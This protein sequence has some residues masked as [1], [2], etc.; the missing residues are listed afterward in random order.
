MLA[1]CLESQN[2]KVLYPVISWHCRVGWEPS[3]SIEVFYCSWSHIPPLLWLPDLVS[4]MF[5]QEA[6]IRWLLWLGSKEKAGGGDALWCHRLLSW[7]DSSGI[8]FL[9]RGEVEE[10]ILVGEGEALEDE[11]LPPPSDPEGRDER[12]GTGGALFLPKKPP[13]STPLFLTHPSAFT[14]SPPDP[15]LSPSSGCGWT[16]RLTSPPGIGLSGACR[17]DSWPPSAFAPPTPAV[18][19]APIFV[20]ELE[21]AVR[22]AQNSMAVALLSLSSGPKSQSERRASGAWLGPC[23]DV[24]PVRSKT[25]RLRLKFWKSLQKDRWMESVRV[26]MQTRSI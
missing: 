9:C 21:L 3:R 22:Q 24:W 18:I 11:S 14:P 1:S 20:V 16:F 19:I 25:P 7:L 2:K 6:S 13:S 10:A 23:V 15:T 5:L 12:C 8:S 4:H 26:W 17:G